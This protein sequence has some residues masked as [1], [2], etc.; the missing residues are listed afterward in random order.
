[1]EN[2]SRTI[3]GIELKFL[4]LVMLVSHIPEQNQKMVREGAM[5]T[6]S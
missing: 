4:H 3:N 5:L 1:M 6:W 2:A